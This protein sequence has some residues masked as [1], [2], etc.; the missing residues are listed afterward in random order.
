MFCAA[1]VFSVLCIVECFSKWSGFWAKAW[2]DFGGPW[3]ASSSSSSVSLL[4]TSEGEIWYTA[5]LYIIYYITHYRGISMICLYHIFHTCVS[6]HSPER[7]DVDLVDALERLCLVSAPWASPILSMMIIILIQY[8]RHQWS[9]SSMLIIVWP[10]MRSR[11]DISF[12]PGSFVCP[13]SLLPLL[14]TVIIIILSW[15]WWL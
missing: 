8:D 10:F 7:E 6:Y 1:V 14:Q 15:F 13:T 9:T 12:S 11:D 4:L 2:S 3:N 5:R